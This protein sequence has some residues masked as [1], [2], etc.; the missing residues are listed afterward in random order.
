MKLEYPNA[1]RDESVLDVYHGVKVIE[2]KLGIMSKLGI[3]LTV[4]YNRSHLFKM[5]K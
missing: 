3:S 4:I 5:F 2:Y 1:R